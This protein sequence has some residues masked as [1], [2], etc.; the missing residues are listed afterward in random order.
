[1]TIP[2]T[3]CHAAS[4]LAALATATLLGA[5]GGG[6]AAPPADTAQALSSHARQEQQGLAPVRLTIQGAKI[7]GP[8]GKPI[9]LRGV[10]V[11]GV[12][13]DGPNGNDVKTIVDSF[14]MNLL[15]L[16]ISFTPENRDD[17]T[18]S[19]FTTDYESK[20]AS[21]V[22]AARTRKLWMVLE[23]RANDK[24]ANDPAF[25]N[26]KKT[27]P[28]TDGTPPERCPNFGYYLRAWK[29]LATTY[30]GFDYIAG[31]G[32]LAEPS[33]DKTGAAD[34][35]QTLIDFQKAL[36]SV[37]HG[38]DPRTPFFIGPAYNYDTMEYTDD[39]YFNAFAADYPNQLVYEVNFLM[40][41]EWIQ[42]GTWT[43]NDKMPTYP[44]ADPVDGYDSLLVPEKPGDPMEKAFNFSRVQD[45]NYQK[46]LS[47][48]FIDWYLQ[49]PL[50]F[51]D[52]HA[53]PLYVDQFGA[54]SFAKGQLAYENDLIQYF[55]KHDLHWSRWSY[56]AYN[57]DSTDSASRTLLPPNDAAIQFYISLAP[58]W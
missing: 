5:C 39:R 42:N 20:I 27:G 33:T 17:R 16:R 47:K 53:V 18:A 28:C 12:S 21:W 10:N 57:E 6:G 30:K 22:A 1:M 38:I 36:M 4:W 15:R 50:R 7:F 34:P 24:V 25:Y 56:N 3:P 9:R 46:T 19:G 37:I 54:S 29:Y 44:K 52:H 48:G 8:D 26:T 43:V 58:N 45:G 41:K 40:P 35:Q 49:W 31:Y 2:M 13:V 51:R 11:D 32:V 23:M 55:E 14:G